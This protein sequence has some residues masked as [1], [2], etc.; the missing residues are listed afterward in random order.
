MSLYLSKEKNNHYRTFARVTDAEDTERVHFEVRKRDREVIAERELF[1]SD[2]G[3]RAL[4][5]TGGRHKD[6]DWSGSL[7]MRWNF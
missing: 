2:D 6:K 5:A 3:K 7:V 4:C 1:I